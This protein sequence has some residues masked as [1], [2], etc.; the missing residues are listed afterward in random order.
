MKTSETEKMLEKCYEV[1]CCGSILLTDTPC[2]SCPVLTD[3][4]LYVEKSENETKEENNEE[5]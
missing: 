5:S 4:R 3:I 2:D 1:G